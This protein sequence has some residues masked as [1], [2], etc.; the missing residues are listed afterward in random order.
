M[1]LSENEKTDWKPMLLVSI[2]V[3]TVVT[4][5]RLHLSQ[6]VQSACQWNK[7]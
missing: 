3:S 1:V 5:K 2:G 6:E 7:Q 4:S